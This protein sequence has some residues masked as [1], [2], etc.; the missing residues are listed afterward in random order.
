MKF[1]KKIGAWFKDAYA[2]VK[3]NALPAT[4]AVVLIAGPAM[5]TNSDGSGVI[6]AIFSV[7]ALA[8]ALVFAD[9]LADS[10]RPTIQVDLGKILVTATWS[11]LITAAI[12]RVAFKLV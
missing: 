6:S 8:S 9:Q 2:F 3:A 11:A 1:I 5:L 7:T 12:K 4:A 10:N